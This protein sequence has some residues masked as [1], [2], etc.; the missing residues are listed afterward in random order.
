MIRSRRSNPEVAYRLPQMTGDF[1]YLEVSWF[2]LA[3]NPQLLC[4]YFQRYHNPYRYA[5]IA[6]RYDRRLQARL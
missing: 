3:E 4:I 2:E 1:D 5:F 6:T